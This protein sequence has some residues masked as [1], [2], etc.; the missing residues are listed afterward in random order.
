M[1][2]THHPTKKKP[3]RPANTR[4]TLGSIVVFLFVIG[5][6]ASWQVYERITG[7]QQQERTMSVAPTS[8]PVHG[9]RRALDGAVVTSTAGQFPPLVSVMIDNHPD[10]RP[11]S[12]L[13]RAPLVYEMPVEGMF[14]RYMAVYPLDDE[15]LSM[16]GA[17]VAIGPVR[18]AR[19][20]FVSIAEELH[21]LYAHVGG[22]G[23]ALEQIK[24]RDILDI[25]EY[26]KGHLFWRERTRHAP[27]NVL[28][29]LFKLDQ[30][31]EQYFGST[32]SSVIGAWGWDEEKV[33]ISSSTPETLRVEIPWKRGN[34]TV[35]W[36]Y[37]AAT[38]KYARWSDGRLQRDQDGTPVMATTII[39]QHVTSRVLDAAGRLAIVMSGSGR[40]EIYRDGVR[41]DATWKKGKLQ[42]RTEWL[43]SAG[44]AVALKPG[45]VWVEVV[46]F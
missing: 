8:T 16:P 38:G 32:T 31:H 44:N 41:I 27:H 42:N 40:T 6:F 23:Q 36:E 21:G 34:D 35:R 18:S 22:S 24:I 13:A 45:A 33:Q 37:D 26:Y 7:S 43:D 9:L 30:G 5:L 28:T 39:V 14:T 4:G 25:N 2:S 29:T 12:G 1:S 19:P 11:L 17:K 10:A 20:Y 3:P 46:D 15:S